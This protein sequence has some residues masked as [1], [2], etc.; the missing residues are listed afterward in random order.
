LQISVSIGELG[1]RVPGPIVL[2]CV[3][4]S[5]VFM[6]VRQQSVHVA[7]I[8]VIQTQFRFQFQLLCLWTTPPSARDICTL[9]N[10]RIGFPTCSC[11]KRGLLWVGLAVGGRELLE[12]DLGMWF[13]YTLRRHHLVVVVTVASARTNINVSHI[14]ARLPLPGS[15]ALGAQQGKLD[16]DLRTSALLGTPSV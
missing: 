12:I 7:D 1:R 13:G 11:V 6:A 10:S 2:L 15:L 3:L 16:A 4:D 5:R 9:F 14:G 8:V